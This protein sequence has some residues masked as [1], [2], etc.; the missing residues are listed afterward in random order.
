MSE[1]E[2]EK[3]HAKIF[4]KVGEEDYRGMMSLILVTGY[5]VG[6]I[7]GA[8]FKSEAIPVI[9]SV[10]GPLAGAAVGWYFREKVK[11]QKIRRK[12]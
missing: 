5:V 12:N 1:E 11:I 2:I 10:L 6:V 3:K 8:I 7:I 4:D 9:S